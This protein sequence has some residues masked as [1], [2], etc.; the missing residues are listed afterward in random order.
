MN[1]YEA[2]AIMRFIASVPYNGL[3]SKADTLIG[4]AASLNFARKGFVVTNG[5]YK[6]LKNVPMRSIRVASE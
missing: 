3:S 6:D 4:T 2:E 5:F 1:P